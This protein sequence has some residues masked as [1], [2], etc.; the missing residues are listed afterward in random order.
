MRVVLDQ[1]VYDF[2]NK[3]NVAMIQTAVER[4]G[5]MWPDASIEVLTIAPH[6][7]RIYCPRAK[8]VSPD[9]SHDWSKRR[10]GM[11]RVL[12]ALPRPAL[13]VLFEMREEAW[14]RKAARMARQA[15]AD[16]LADRP[17]EADEAVEDQLLDEEGGVAHWRR[18]LV[19]GADLVVASGGGYMC[20]IAEHHALSAL[21]TLDAAIHNGI[22]TAMVGQGIGPIHS[23]RLLARAREVLPRVDFIAI[24][25]QRAA[26]PLLLSLGVDP[27][28][29]MLTGDDA[30]ELTY[31]L[32]Q[33]AW[34]NGIGLCMR[35]A[36]Y[37]G[38]AEG[39][40][41]AIRA[42]VQAVAGRH[43][44]PLVGVPIS[45]DLREADA[46][47]VQEIMDGYKPVVTSDWQRFEDTRDLI[48]R[49]GSCRVVVTG[50]YHAAVFALAQ[51]IP[52]ICL[53]RYSTYTDKLSGLADQFGPGC[54][55]VSMDDER[56]EQTLGDAIE[57]AWNSAESLRPG[58]LEVAARQ[59]ELGHAAF[60][61]VTELAHTGGEPVRAPA[62]R[63]LVKEVR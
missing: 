19:A 1:G 12:G 31:R 36:H 35:V 43:A 26:M 53:A 41:R 61:R 38:V 57:E 40:V 46:H 6:L 9:G 63:P 33:P 37:T 24:R 5:E 17:S 59:I 7:L 8:P 27:A 25:E 14:A 42:A 47:A 20:D 56:L 13:R 51:G 22:P 4:F 18:N 30:V 45:R 21:D 52:A 55:V 39:D 10:S 15:E 32:R 48:C 60:R 62:H 28:R 49:V 2:R 58:L 16:A 34:G 50:A 11:D 44:A 54:R 23:A 29:V 3:G